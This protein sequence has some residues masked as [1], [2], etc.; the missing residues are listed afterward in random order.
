VLRTPGAL[1]AHNHTAAYRREFKAKKPFPV[2]KPLAAAPIVVDDPADTPPFDFNVDEPAGDMAAPPP[3]PRPA[4]L[5]V[6]PRPR[7]VLPFRGTTE[8]REQ[9]P[10]KE[11]P[12]EGSPRALAA[13]KEEEC[14]AAAVPLPYY[15]KHKA[16]VLCA[17]AVV[18]VKAGGVRVFWHC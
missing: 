7:I 17:C 13:K 18:H 9:Y 11:V 2:T 5:P 8:Y 10:R 14:I 15:L 6:A 12:R 4:A 1:R 3:P 16:S